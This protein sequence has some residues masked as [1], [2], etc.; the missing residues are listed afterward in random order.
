MQPICFF[1]KNEL[2]MEALRYSNKCFEIH[3]IHV[4]L[5]EFER[6]RHVHTVKHFS[7]GGA[8]NI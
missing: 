4:N 3:R 5:E 2:W 8:A 6:V 1:Y 7:D